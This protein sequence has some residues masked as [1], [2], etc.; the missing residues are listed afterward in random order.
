MPKEITWR[1]ETHVA[2]NFQNVGNSSHK[3]WSTP[4]VSPDTFSANRAQTSFLKR[5]G[6]GTSVGTQDLLPAAASRMHG[7]GRGVRWGSNGFELVLTS[8]FGNLLLIQARETF[9]L[10]PD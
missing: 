2:G 8:D 10:A 3:I 1:R 9:V 4:R 6:R 5:F 7:G